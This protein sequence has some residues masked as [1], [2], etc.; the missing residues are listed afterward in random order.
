MNR[1][2]FSTIAG[3]IATLASVGQIRAQEKPLGTR[4][5]SQPAISA[6]HIAFA[7]DRDLWVANRD[8]SNPRRLTSHEGT[9]V[10]PRFSPDGNWIAST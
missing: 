8:G 1:V 10:S 4:M 6:N 2:L 5:L 9:E 3:L 7:Y